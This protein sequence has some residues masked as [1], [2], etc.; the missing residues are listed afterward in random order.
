MMRR[1]ELAADVLYK[2]GLIRGFCHLYDGQEAVIVGMDAALTPADPV[3]TS[4][5][6]HCTHLSR[7]GTQV[8]VLSELL[9]RS[10]GAS[11][12]FGGSMHMYNK[13]Y[14][15]YG[16]N[17]IVGAQ[18]PLGAGLAFAAKYNNSE[19]VAVTM[20]GDGA[21]NQGQ[22]YEAFNIAALWKLPCLFVCENN[23]YGMGTST[24]RSA[25]QDSYYTRGDYVPGVYIDG[26]DVVAVKEGFKFAKEFA[27]ACGPI[28]VELDTYRYHGH[29]MSDPG[30]TYRTRDEV[31]GV[32]E[33]RDP[34]DRVK[35]LLLDYNI[36]AGNEIKNIEKEI[37]K[38]LEEDIKISKSS[39]PPSPSDLLNHVYVE[40]LAG[41]AEVRFSVRGEEKIMK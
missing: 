19:N 38:Q 18:C 2:G 6:D 25:K 31:S 1:L 35:K 22:L 26:M 41:N 33:S 28:V 21:A 40:K 16:G 8:E 29:S 4:Y 17:G 27:L 9:G 10:A 20:Y 23:H 11:G 24:S 32:R 15:F 13:K 12:G 3:V 7:G 37:K 30:S 14:Q 39:P 5:R 34:V 36:L